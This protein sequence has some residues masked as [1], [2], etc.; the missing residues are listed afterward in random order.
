[1]PKTL[2]EIAL[3]PETMIMLPFAIILD[4]IGIGLVIFALDDFWITDIIGLI[5]IGSWSF[6][7]TQFIAA[8]EAAPIQMP[9]LGGKKKTMEQLKEARKAFQ[10]TARETAKAQKTAKIAKWGKRLKWLE[11][12]PYIGALPLWSVSVY[13]T[14]KYT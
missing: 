8:P 1:M 14:I 13:M 4:A 9:A 6:F 12:I 3:N 5:F 7:R 2:L 10:E 11:F